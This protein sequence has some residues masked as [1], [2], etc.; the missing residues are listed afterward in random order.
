M[1]QPSPGIEQPDEMAIIAQ[2]LNWIG[3]GH[4]VSLATVVSTWGSSP[5]PVGSHLLIRDDNLFEGSVSGGCIEGEVVTEALAVI[6]SGS[7]A[8]LDFGVSDEDAWSVGLACGGEVQVF[9]QKI[10]S[11]LQEVLA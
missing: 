8:T 1:T 2:A 10:S 6:R 11:G 4:E 5:R 7:V 3:A 9:V